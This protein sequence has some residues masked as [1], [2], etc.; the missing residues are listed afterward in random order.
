MTL[1]HLGPGLANGLANLHDA[2]RAGSPV[3]EPGGRARELAS[4]AR[5]AAG[6]RHRAAGRLDVGLGACQ[7]LVGRARRGRRGGDRRGVGGQGGDADRAGRVPVGS[8]R[9]G[10]RRCPPL[11]PEPVPRRGSRGRQQQRWRAPR[12]LR[13]CSAGRRCTEAGLRAAARIAAATGARV[14]T[15]TFVARAE[16]GR[17]LPDPPRLPYF[18]EQ[19]R[20]A[21]AGVEELVL[22]GARP[23]VAFFGDPDDAELDGTGGCGRHDAGAARRRTGRR[24]WSVALE[25]VADL[26]GAPDV[27]R[28]GP[29][30]S[31]TRRRGTL[32]PETLTAAVVACL[33]EGAVVVDEGTTTTLAYLSQA[34]GAPRHTYLGHVGGAIGQGTTGGRRRGARR[35]G[36]P[37][38]RAAGRRQRSVH[39][40]G[41]VDPGP[42]GP[43]TSRRWCAPTTATGSC[44]SN[45]P[46]PGRSRSGRPARA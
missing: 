21:L 46:G 17:G 28:P 43:R 40:A 41:A 23:P 29:G 30:P 4:A 18:P 36:P 42:G 20:A 38:H 34:A 22:A 9:A 16:W 39:G 12:R 37:G 27:R 33:P 13:C 45:S 25:R 8:G 1:L 24:R 5:P 6:E 19:A 31:P 11:R 14:L 26:L 7:R 35:T 44:R 32:T 3:R 10:V 15:D 2:R